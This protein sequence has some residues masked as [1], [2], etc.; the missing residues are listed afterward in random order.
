M[1]RRIKSKQTRKPKLVRGR[2]NKT[3]GVGAALVAAAAPTVANVV[4][5][6]AVKVAK[7]AAGLA[8]PVVDKLAAGMRKFATSEHQYLYGFVDPE[9]GA[10][11][12]GDGSAATFVPKHRMF[13]DFTV[14]DLPA[15]EKSG[16]NYHPCNSPGWTTG[17]QGVVSGTDNMAAYVDGNAYRNSAA[18][19]IVFVACPHFARSYHGCLAPDLTG[20]VVGTSQVVSKMSSGFVASNVIFGQVAYTNR[21]TNPQSAVEDAAGAWMKPIGNFDIEPFSAPTTNQYLQKDPANASA[22]YEGLYSNLVENRLTGIKISVTCNMPALTATGQVMG[23]DNS[24][25]YGRVPEMI[26]GTHN[27][28]RETTAWESANDIDPDDILFTGTAFSQSRQDLGPI[29]HGQTY[30]ATFIPKGDHVIKWNTMPL[31]KAALHST[32]D[33]AMSSVSSIITQGQFLDANYYNIQSMEQ[34]CMN[35]P[36]A[37][38]AI[39]G[40]PTG[41]TFRVRVTFSVENVVKNNTALALVRDSARFSSRFLPDWSKIAAVNGACAGACSNVCEAACTNSCVAEGAAAAAGLIPKQTGRPGN[42]NA[43][44]IGA[45]NAA[46]TVVSMPGGVAALRRP[47]PDRTPVTNYGNGMA[48]TNVIPRMPGNMGR[49]PV[50]GIN[51]VGMGLGG[52]H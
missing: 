49:Y 38:I 32:A 28:I 43:Y 51:G 29:T 17:I 12:P 35:L 39:T 24:F 3:Q 31:A 40:C 2:N 44:A 16:L 52:G 41:A 26:V 27:G 45:T 9:N 10:P 5:N 23:G 37:Y 34:M 20:A 22:F 14:A 7:K 13:K 19:P 30:E 6:V 25:L 11:G 36:M 15:D 1:T 18:D 33:G 8:A 48:A 4:K 50:G 46:L 21:W 42:P 47:P